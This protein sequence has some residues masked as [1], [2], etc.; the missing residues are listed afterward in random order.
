MTNFCSDP[1]K[2]KE[3]F[4]KGIIS[5]YDYNVWL[6]AQNYQ[7]ELKKSVD[8]EII[9][10]TTY[11]QEIMKA[12][13][14]HFQRDW[15]TPGKVS[16]RFRYKLVGNFTP[17]DLVGLRKSKEDSLLKKATE[18]QPIQKSSNI[19]LKDVLQKV[20]DVTNTLNDIVKKHQARTISVPQKIIKSNQAQP[21][22]KAKN[23]A[24]SEKS[25]GDYYTKICEVATILL[26]KEVKIKEALKGG[27]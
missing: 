26:D 16:E 12:G 20:T 24:L 15:G 25:S 22:Q 9:S 14:V 1:I 10:K 2:I 3:A 21:L 17:L 27:R 8:S 7:V 18:S 13:G 5:E 6:G 11:A 19:S 4:G 23:S